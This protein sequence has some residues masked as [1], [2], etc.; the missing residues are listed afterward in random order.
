MFLRPR[1]H[2]QAF[3]RHQMPGFL[4][5]VLP[6]RTQGMPAARFAPA[7]SYAKV[8]SVRVSHHRSHR[9]TGIPCAM[10]L[11]FPSCSPRRPGFVVSVVSATHKHCRQLDISVGT[12]GP[13][14][15]SV[16]FII[17]RQS[18]PKRPSHPAPNVRDDRETP[19][20][21]R[22]TREEVPVICPTSQAI[23]LR[24]I[25]TTGKSVGAGKMMSSDE[26]KP[27]RCHQTASRRDR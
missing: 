11:R 8:I 12:S 19:S 18:M 24:Q 9:S 27:G 3:P 15:F 10:V 4:T 20:H 7:A 2:G 26:Q 5:E 6:W 23:C 13:H 1:C 21:G 17:A 16:R 25:N 14:D 22:G